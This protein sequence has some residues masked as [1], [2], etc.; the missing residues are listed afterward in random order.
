MPPDIESRTSRAPF[1]SASKNGVNEKMGVTCTGLR[2]ILDHPMP[3]A[4]W[5]SARQ[6]VEAGRVDRILEIV[7]R[8]GIAFNAVNIST[9]FHRLAK[10][11]HDPQVSALWTPP[12]PRVAHM[13]TSLVGLNDSSA[14]AA[15]AAAAVS[16]ELETCAGWIGRPISECEGGQGA[17][18]ADCDGW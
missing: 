6:I 14:A 3:V 16:E 7:E 17:E 1:R 8:S 18:R 13:C 4:D 10:M 9:A 5:H 15:A 2:D 11:W 12:L